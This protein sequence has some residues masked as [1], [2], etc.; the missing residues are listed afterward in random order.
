MSRREEP[1]ELEV[2]AW[3]L[4]AELLDSGAV[5]SGVWR[6]LLADMSETDFPDEP[7]EGVL[8]EMMV[9]SAMPALASAG[10]EGCSLASALVG[11]IRD[12][13]M[14]DLR[15]ASEVAEMEPVN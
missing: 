4:V 5:L 8:L 1:T 6:D 2:A 10:P 14:S 9:G 3:R 11:A 13:V 12:H 7:L 15:L